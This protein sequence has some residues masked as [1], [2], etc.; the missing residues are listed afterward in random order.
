MYEQ[1]NTMMETKTI[2]QIPQ[3]LDGD[4]FTVKTLRMIWRACA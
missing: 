2:F 3:L 1:T 4:D